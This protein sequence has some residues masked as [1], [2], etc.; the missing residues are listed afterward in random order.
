[1]MV[2]FLRCTDDAALDMRLRAKTISSLKWRTVNPVNFIFLS[3]IFF[4]IAN[5]SND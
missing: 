1:M 5:L 3:V 4:N 2:S